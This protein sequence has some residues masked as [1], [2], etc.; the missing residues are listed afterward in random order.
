MPRPLETGDPGALKVP[1]YHAN[2][3]FDEVI[4]YHA[5]EFFSRGGI[6]P[7]MVTFHPQGIH[8]GPHPKAVEAVRD[9][10]RTNEEAVMVDARHPLDL[11][12]EAGS[13]EV[14]DYWKSWMNEEG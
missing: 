7:G 12:A 13:A 4:F 8:H 9:K 3:D 11:T 6:E 10:T 14:R 2:I 1:F 5:G